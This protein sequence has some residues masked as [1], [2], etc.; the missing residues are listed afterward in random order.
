MPGVCGI[1][2]IYLGDHR[3][4]KGSVEHETNEYGTLPIKILIGRKSDG[5]FCDLRVLD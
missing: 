5:M 2:D 3:P 1:I 4:I